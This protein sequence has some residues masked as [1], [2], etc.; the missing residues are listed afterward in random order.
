MKVIIEIPDDNFNELRKLAEVNAF[1]D[2]LMGYSLLA[3]AHGTVLPKGHGDL[4][5]RDKLIGNIH[6]TKSIIATL[7]AP[8]IIPADKEG[9]HESNN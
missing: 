9:R 1:S 8:A 6:G 4:I 3:I 2:N 7:D 5:D